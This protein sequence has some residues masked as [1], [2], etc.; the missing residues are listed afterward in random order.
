[1]ADNILFT[2]WNCPCGDLIIASLGNKL[3]M[4]DW[5]NGWH[6]ASIMK[7]FDRLLGLPWVQKSSDVIEHAIEELE[8]YFERQRQNFDLPLLLVGTDFQIKVWQALQ[9]IPYGQ[10]CSYADIART[11]GNAHAVRAVGGAVGQN[12]FS[13]I[14]P[15]HRVLG[16]D[17]SL[18]GYG[19]GYQAKEYL[20]NI[21]NPQSR[22]F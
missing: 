11:V 20:L 16:S 22:L 3:V 5:E 6:H 17:R 8:S 13:I 14:I 2:R 12:P 21:E 9:K 10:T 19:G 4:S 18:T 1:M 15:C 7:R